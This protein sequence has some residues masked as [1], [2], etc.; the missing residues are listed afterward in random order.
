MFFDVPTIPIPEDLFVLVRTDYSDEQAW[1]ELLDELALYPFAE[2][3]EVRPVSDG[4]WTGASVEEVL[5]AIVPRA[6]LYG[7]YIAD[8]E[9]M[10]GR[11]GHPVLA[12]SL[13]EPSNDENDYCKIRFRVVADELLDMHVQ[14]FIDNL[15]WEH[16]CIRARE[17]GGVYRG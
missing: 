13:Q 7:I 5:A 15:D 11:Q 10:N 9:A 17:A 3:M 1:E 4:A 12:V 8:A 2:S 14:L 16:Y 6:G